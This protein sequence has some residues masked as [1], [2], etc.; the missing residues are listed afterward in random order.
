MDYYI[1]TLALY[2]AIILGF[3]VKVSFLLNLL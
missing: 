1:N 3:V 2:F